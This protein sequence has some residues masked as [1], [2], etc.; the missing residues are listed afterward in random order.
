MEAILT[1]LE[2]S[3]VCLG[4]PKRVTTGESLCKSDDLE[5]YEAILE[6]TEE[7][8]VRQDCRAVLG[9][10]YRVLFSLMYGREKGSSRST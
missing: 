8:F 4:P 9:S 3:E 2:L 6:G 7:L 1:K 10:G 5:I